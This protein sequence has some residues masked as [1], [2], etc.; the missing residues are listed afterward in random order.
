[1]KSA[2]GSA[3]L[4]ETLR[5]AIPAGP[6][7]EPIAFRSTGPQQP[8]ATFVWYRTEQARFEA[9][10]SADAAAPAGR[11]LDQAGN[12]MPVPVSVSVREEGASRWA[13][14]TF[15]LAPLSPADYVLELS[16]GAARR[17]IALR[18]ER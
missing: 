1:M 11:L 10:L 8:V 6:I 5:V 15:P 2:G 16:S 12:P 3:S 18:V 13:V 7:G 14:A 4:L 9:P 17:Y